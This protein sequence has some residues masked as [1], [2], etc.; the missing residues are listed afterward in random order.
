MK[1]KYVGIT[2]EHDRKANTISL[3][4]PG[5]IEKALARFQMTDARKAS[6]P[7]IYTPPEYGAKIHFDEVEDD[8]PITAEEK[9]RIQQ[10]VGVLLFY[11]RA[12]DPTMLC[13]VN[14]LASHQAEPSATSTRM[15]RSCS[16]PVIC[17]CDATVT[18][19][20]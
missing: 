14:K 3:S 6:S 9:T 4:M 15:P 7:A 19:P 5:Y 11:A 13:A 20:T 10:I 16:R 2:I 18:R 8:T 17:N 1:P 12:V